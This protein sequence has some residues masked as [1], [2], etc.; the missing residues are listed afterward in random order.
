[1]PERVINVVIV[2]GGISG[3]AQAVRLQ[4]KLGNRVKYTIYERTQEIGGVWAHSKWR[5]AGVDVPI[6]LYSLYSHPYA[7]FTSKYARREEVLAYW[8]RIAAAHR[9]KDNVVFETE[10]VS[11]RWDHDTQQHHVRFRNIATGETFEVIAEFLIAATGALNQ[12]RIPDIPGRTDFE[13]TQFHSSN[14]HT[15]VDLKNKRVAV[16]GNG[17]SA[18]QI[19]PGITE[20]EGLELINFIRSPGY[21]R[22][23]D[24]FE[25]SRFTRFVFRYVPFALKLYRLSTFQEYEWG[26]VG[27]GLGKVATRIRERVA[28]NLIDYMKRELPEKYWKDLLPDYPLDCKR[29]GYDAG[30]LRSFRRD[31][32]ELVS[33]PIVRINEEGIETADGRSFALDII[34][35]ATGFAVTDTGVGLN[36]GVFGE[37]GVE[38][39]EKFARAGGA[40]GYLGVSFAGVPNYFAVLGPNAIAMSW[41]TTLGNNTE[42]IARIIQAV[43]ERNL[44]S[45]VVKDDVNEKYN[46]Y[47]QKRV[48]NS[49][50]YQPDCG[51]SWYKDP[52]SSRVTVP[53]P[54]GATELWALTRKIKFEDWIFRRLELPHPSGRPQIVTIDVKT[55]WNRTPVGTF[56]DWF[57]NRRRR[58]FELAMVRK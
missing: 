46:A 21:F 33:S 23:K 39:S 17:S 52:S 19:I 38:L 18:I 24:N 55:P 43:Y 15:D 58:T 50:W 41:G 1:M 47:I 28:R 36:H 11:S 45:I 32:V 42:F 5:G 16:V 25:Y 9:V 35:F 20:I 2:G 13:G 30:W 22:P 4:E 12:P 48:S 31:N 37:D 34:V 51:G 40:Y 49:I 54:F 57:A 26:L 6:H 14:W 53:A 3:I 29:V 7:G 56:L 27:Q 8:K 10:F 44:S